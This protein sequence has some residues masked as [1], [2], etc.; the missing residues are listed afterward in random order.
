MAPLQGNRSDGDILVLTWI[1]PL[2]PSL[3]RRVIRGFD[4][5]WI[6]PC[7]L[8]YYFCPIL[9]SQSKYNL[10]CAAIQPRSTRSGVQYY[11]VLQLES[12]G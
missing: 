7:A 8:S 4:H 1:I 2:N 3:T 12:Y 11:Y 5:A 9:L 10:Y 6:S